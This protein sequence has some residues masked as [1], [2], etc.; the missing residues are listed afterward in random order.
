MRKDE[1]LTLPVPELPRV[2]YVG[3]GYYTSAYYVVEPTRASELET[4][5]APETPE[6]FDPELE[7][8]YFL[9]H[10][11]PEPESAAGQKEPE[12]HRTIVLCHGLAAS[13]L[14]FVLDAHFFAERG[15]RVIV[16]DLRGH[17]RSKMPDQSLRSEDDFTI[18]MMAD[19]LVAILDKEGVRSTHWV[20]NSLGGI[21]ALSLM[22]S[23]ATRLRDVV[24]F[25]TSFSFDVPRYYFTL[26]QFASKLVSRENHARL[27]ARLTTV[28]PEAQAIVYRMIL[29]TDPEIMFTI[30]RHLSRYDL[31]EH[32]RTFDGAMLMLRGDKDILVNQALSKTLSAMREH[33]L[34]FLKDISN[35]GHCA[36]L[37]QPEVVRD[38]ILGFVSGSWIFDE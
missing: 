24:T 10:G 3:R 5:P 34:F 38:E 7:P 36:N 28:R 9:E 6:E 37:D 8:D 13:G 30:A 35:A 25:G 12:E 17:G 18:K 23:H 21:L 1:F 32:A 19:D 33:D 22:G 27:G 16:P 11:Y 14:Q 2:R 20:G 4:A 29:K 31:I 26:L 15:F